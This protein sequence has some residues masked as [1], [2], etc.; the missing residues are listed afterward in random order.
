[1]ATTPR[2]KPSRR[3]ACA[4]RCFGAL[5]LLA[6]EAAAQSL[7][8]RSPTPLGPGLSGAS[9][10]PSV[11]VD[12]SQACAAWAVADQGFGQVWSARSNGRGVHWLAPVRVDSDSTGATKITSPDSVQ[13]LGDDFFV[14]WIDARNGTQRDDVFVNASTD[15][16]ATFA[17]LEVQLPDGLGGNGEVR[18][19]KAVAVE[20]TAHDAL[21]AVMRVAPNG[22]FDEELHLTR[23]ID[24]GATWS[25]PLHVAGDIAQGHDV[26]QFDVYADTDAV[27]LVWEDDSANGAGRYSPYHARS[28]D[29]GATFSV[30]Q[31]L[32]V[33]DLTDAGNCDA[34]GDYGLR[35]RSNGPNVVVAWLEERLHPDNEELRL[36]VSTDMGATFA[37]DIRIGGADPLAADVDY[38]DLALAHDRIV[39]AF[40]DDRLN[41]GSTDALYVWRRH[42]NGTTATETLLSGP[43]GATFP[44]LCG[45][46]SQIALA[47]TTDMNR[48][49]LL[50][51]VSENQ[52]ASWAPIATLQ[53]SGSIYDVD[54]ASIAFEPGYDN[55]F[56]CYLIDTGPFGQNRAHMAG[57]RSPTLVP[58]GFS[59]AAPLV[60]FRGERLLGDSD[61]LFLIVVALSQAEGAFLLPDLRDTGLA[62]DTLTSAGITL[63]PSLL[64]PIQP[65]GVATTPQLVN[66]LPPGLTFQAVGVTLDVYGNTQ[67]VTDVATVTVTP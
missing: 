24:G 34:P 61:V 40:T 2:P 21:I 42:V 36:T 33:T 57:V 15:G 48:Q 55:V 31:A 37:P 23:S 35:V 7:A 38:I 62:Y 56:A 6:P 49:S 16:G 18:A 4:A 25:A 22:V 59:P 63:L 26:D 32:D 43:A 9:G 67:R 8:P 44:R 66:H 65:N 13:R 52:G 50:A 45:T 64:A 39:L 10:A 30:A 47:W 19:F 5:A 14:F 28:T 58:Q 60:G 29:G 46:G 1:M 41:P 12:T 17:P 27:H 11:A 20:G 3:L 51:R 53:S 54:N